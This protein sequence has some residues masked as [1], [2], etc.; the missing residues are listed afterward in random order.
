MIIFSTPSKPFAYSVK[1]TA[2]RQAVISDYTDEI[3]AL[4]EANAGS[5]KVEVPVP[6]TWAAEETR[7]FVREVVYKALG[8]DIGV[9]TDIF[10]FGCDRF[11]A[12]FS[13]S[14]KRGSNTSIKPARDVDL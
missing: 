2:R 10:Q 7:T 1:G 11:V 4:Y 12:R 9:D 3:N 13:R 8:S 14:L 5:T 6:S